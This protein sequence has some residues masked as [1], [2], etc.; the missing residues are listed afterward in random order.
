MTLSALPKIG[1][2]LIRELENS[3][4]DD[5]QRIFEMSEAA[6]RSHLS[7]ERRRAVVNWQRYFDIEREL[8]LME[9]WDTCYRI[10][11]DA[12]FPEA[13]IPLPDCPAGLYVSAA[14]S[15]LERCVA[16]IGTRHPSQY[17]R[18]VARDFAG[19]LA[20][21]GFTIVSGLARGID[22][23][24]HWAALQAGGRTAAVLGCGLDQ[25]YPPENRDLMEEIRGSAGVWTEFYFGRKADRQT[26][27]QRNRIVSGVSLAVIVIESGEKGGSMITARFAL[28]Q[29]K[30]VFAVPGRIDQPN[31]AGCHQLIQ[32]G[33]QV[34]SSVEEIVR[35]LSMEIP[36]LN[37]ATQ[38]T[39]MVA[40][41]PAQMYRQLSAEEM[42]VLG[43]L[44]EGDCLFADQLCDQLGLSIARV[45]TALMLLEIKG[46][47]SKR[48]EGAFERT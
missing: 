10:P 1:P 19:H 34:A 4:G 13:L 21:S 15:K 6:L 16:I 20:S 7:V 31:A 39:R 38:T 40:E 36:E 26:F 41:S 29:G 25:L 30:M 2:V 35:V 43:A 44:N 47:V 14:D 9:H 23:E 45:S 27:P 3:L 42:A 28:D 8:Q 12:G 32:D 33:A 11:G 5:F 46:L 17:G 37:L 22:T 24:A 18:K 48:I